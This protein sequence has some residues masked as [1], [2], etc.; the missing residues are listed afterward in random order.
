MTANKSLQRTGGRW[1]LVCE[2]LAGIDN[3]PI[4][5]LGEPPAGELSRYAAR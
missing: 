4:I 5:S 3:V 2:S 1:Y